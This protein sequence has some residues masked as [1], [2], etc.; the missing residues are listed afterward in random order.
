M[1][2]HYNFQDL[3]STLF[4]GFSTSI[5]QMELMVDKEVKEAFLEKQVISFADEIDFW[6][7][8][9]YEYVPI[10]IRLFGFAGGTERNE[11]TIEKQFKYSKY[12]S[13]PQKRSWANEGTGVITSIKKFNN[14]PWPDPDEIDLSIYSKIKERLPNGIG[15]IGVIPRIFVAVWMLMGYE[16]FSYAIFDQPEL[17]SRVFAKVGEIQCKTFYRLCTEIDV[18][19]MWLGD[20]IAYRS[21]LMASPLILNRYLFPWYKKMGDICKSKNIPFIYHS[22][23]DLTQVI[24]NIINCGINGL[25]PIEPNAMDA[26]KL[27]K[28]YGKHICIIGNIELDT[29][30]RGSVQDVMELTLSRLEQLWDYGGYCPGSSNSITDYVPLENYQTMLSSIQNFRENHR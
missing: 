5:H 11:I 21:G 20:D 15:L 2:T 25:H 26:I 16:F 8:A 23:G 17:V 30:S 3:Q 12:K 14:F 10:V 4:G 22:D 7:K 13:S 19:A 18:G 6:Y 29:L 9:G 27:K 28:E 24:D 1:S